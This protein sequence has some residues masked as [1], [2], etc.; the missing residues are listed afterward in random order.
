MKTVG[1]ELRDPL[2]GRNG[3]DEEQEAIRIPLSSLTLDC[4]LRVL[5]YLSPRNL[6]CYSTLS[7]TQLRDEHVVEFTNDFFETRVKTQFPGY[8]ELCSRV[9][10]RF[11]LG[12]HLPA[13]NFCSPCSSSYADIVDIKESEPGESA[14]GHYSVLLRQPRG[15][16]HWLQLTA[17]DELAEDQENEEDFADTVVDVEVDRKHILRFRALYIQAMKNQLCPHIVESSDVFKNKAL[18]IGERNLFCGK[19]WVKVLATLVLVV[20]LPVVATM[21]NEG[22]SAFRK[23]RPNVIPVCSEVSTAEEC[24]DLCSNNRDRCNYFEYAGALERRC[25]LFTN[26]ELV[27]QADALERRFKRPLKWNDISSVSWV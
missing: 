13:S 22:V 25:T 17:H 2:L 4:Q 16:G 24:S 27:I 3:D 20:L 8:L 19:L 15:D 14:D 9:K 26:H 10:G 1:T 12:Q 7:R 6:S 21:R 18:N 11:W 5:T 23:Q